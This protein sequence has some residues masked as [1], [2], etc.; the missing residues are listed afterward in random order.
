MEFKFSPIPN[1]FKIKETVTQDNYLVN[2][3]LVSWKGD[4]LE[5]PLLSGLRSRSSSSIKGAPST[6]GRTSPSFRRS[7][8]C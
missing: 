2:G 3:K 8:S 1:H 6:F 7:T 5:D 4:C